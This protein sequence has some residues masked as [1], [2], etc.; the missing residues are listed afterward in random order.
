MNFVSNVQVLQNWEAESSFT[1]ECGAVLPNVRVAYHVYGD[2]ARQ[3][4]AWICHALTANSDPLEWWPGLVGS[5]LTIDT[6]RFAVVCANV[7]GSCYG[8]TGPLSTDP[9]TGDCWLARFPLVSIRD[10]AFL[11]RL[12]ANY[13][14]IDEIDLLI[15]GSMG[16]SRLLSGP[17]RSRNAFVN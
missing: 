1:L 12:L 10:M 9:S 4:V 17:S 11:H 7:L 5:G 13:L 16:G 15:G 6:N 8:T 3:P 2:P 14:E